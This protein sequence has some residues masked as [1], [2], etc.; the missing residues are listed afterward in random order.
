MA[1]LK[2]NPLALLQKMEQGSV[3]NAPGLHDEME[4]VVLWTGVGFK[5]VDMLLIAPLGHVSEVLPCPTFTPV[6]GTKSWVKGVANVRG[7]LLTIIDL[8]EYFG[9]EPVYIDDKARLM[10]MNVEELSTALI[11]NEVLG[12]RH[13]DEELE[14]HDVNV[15]DDPV[16]KHLQRAFLRDDVLWGVFDFMSLAENLTFR[17]VAA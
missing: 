12:L 6:P 8:P 1:D 16:A 7:N 2:N 4:N 17:H 9:K 14:S 5:L 13:F 3:T 11:V 10:V 15:I